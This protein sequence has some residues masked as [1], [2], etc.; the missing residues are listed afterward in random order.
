MA[1]VGFNNTWCKRAVYRSLDARGGAL[2]RRQALRQSIV[3]WCRKRIVYVQEIQEIQE[4]QGTID[5]AATQK[6][7]VTAARAKFV[8]ERSRR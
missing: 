2:A 4:I 6:G 3:D 1:A 7:V 8:V 5:E